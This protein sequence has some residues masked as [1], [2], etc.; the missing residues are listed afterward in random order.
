MTD[1]IRFGVIGAGMMG[2]EHI[3]NV[4]AIDGAELTALADPHQPSIEM[5]RKTADMPDLPAFGGAL[6][7][8]RI[9]SCGLGGEWRRFLLV[10][11]PDSS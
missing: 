3:G 5:S 1:P 10:A 6:R 7:R 2:N 8:P 9:G 4:L 11:L